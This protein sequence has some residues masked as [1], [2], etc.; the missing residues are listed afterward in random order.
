M[1]FALARAAAARGAEVTLVAGPVSLPTPPGVRRVDVTTAAEMAAAI[2]PAAAAQDLIIMAAAVADYRPVEAAGDKLKKDAL[3][4]APSIAL[5]P[6]TDILA[7]LGAQRTPSGGAPVLVGFAAETTAVLA[8]AERK[9]RR[10]GCDLLVVNDVTE[11]GAGFSVD[12]NRVALL[13]L[14][15][16]GDGDRLQ[17]DALPLM[18]K[19]AVAEAILD[20][21][22]ARLVVGK[23]T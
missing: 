2:L 3:G 20:R 1:G 22:A 15:P 23:D 21:A 11:P 18:S 6:T 13:S 4:G 8:H 12:T 5:T 16:D 10:K 9:L 14:V 17:V 7:T 19:D